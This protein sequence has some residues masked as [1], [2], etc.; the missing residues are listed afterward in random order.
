MFRSRILIDRRFTRTRR[1]GETNR[2]ENTERNSKEPTSRAQFRDNNNN[3]RTVLSN[4]FDFIEQCDIEGEND[5]L[6]SMKIKN[7]RYHLTNNKF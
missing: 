1:S 2:T 7:W 3:N 4:N 6:E 5:S